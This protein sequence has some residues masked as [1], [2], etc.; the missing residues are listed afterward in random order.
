MMYAMALDP[1]GLLPDD[2][3]GAERIL[4]IDS[5]TGKRTELNI[6]D[7]PE[8]ITAILTDLGV[9][10]VITPE[11]NLMAR[12][13]FTVAGIRLY[14]AFGI[15][16]EKNIELMAHD[17]LPFLDESG[18]EYSGGCSPSACSTCASTCSEAA[19]GN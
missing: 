5:D 17:S 15:V 11:M 18:L 9:S 6:L 2:F 16:P 10:A 4:V 14:R 3:R 13:A 7:H 1:S 8:G 19:N 12:K